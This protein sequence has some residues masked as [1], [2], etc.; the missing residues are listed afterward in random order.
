MD[1]AVP[2]LALLYRLDPVLQ[3][4]LKTVLAKPDI[5]LDTDTCSELEDCR[6]R[7]HDLQPVI[8][9]CPYEAA[10]DESIQAFQSRVP[11]IVVSRVPDTRE[12]ISA[13]EAGACDYCAPPFELTQ[14]RWML[15]AAASGV[16]SL[17]ATA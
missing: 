9:F 7:L 13:M 15:R 8:L 11:V 12:W 2:R 1:N 3:S 14:L 16:T 5:G 17:H 6:Q 4:E 10:L